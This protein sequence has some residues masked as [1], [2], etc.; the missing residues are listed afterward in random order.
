MNAVAQK[1]FQ[2]QEQSLSES[3]LQ[4]GYIIFDVEDREALAKIRLR[5]IEITSDETTGAYTF[6]FELDQEAPHD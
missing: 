1:I 3:F 6:L 4:R 2:T 5:I